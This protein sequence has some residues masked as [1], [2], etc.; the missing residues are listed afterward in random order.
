[1]TA[2]TDLS[3]AATLSAELDNVTQGLAIIAAGGFT[4]ALQLTGNGFG[5]ANVT[6]NMAAAA[7]TALLTNRQTAI[8][9]ALTN[10]GVT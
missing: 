6:I 8:Q 7:L 10:L 9:T 5:G 2:R 3:R 1:M 4:Q